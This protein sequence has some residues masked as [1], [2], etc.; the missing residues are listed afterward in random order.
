MDFLA[1]A[2]VD[3]AMGLACLIF[4]LMWNGWRAA[5]DVAN[6]AIWCSV[7]LWCCWWHAFK[8]QGQVRMRKPVEDNVSGSAC[9][10]HVGVL[11][12]ESCVC[13]DSMFRR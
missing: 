11:K 10:C 9:R 5:G 12:E 1:L 3:M 8:S 4:V 7:G 2:P 6:V 13:A